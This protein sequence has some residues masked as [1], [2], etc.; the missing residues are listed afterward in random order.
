MNHLYRAPTWSAWLLALPVV[1]LLLLVLVVPV[2]SVLW[3][4]FSPEDGQGPAVTLRHYFDFLGKPLSHQVVVRTLRISVLTTIL[5]ILI[6]YPLAY[7]LA[8]SRSRLR[9]VFL[10]ICVFPLLVS[11]VV[12]AYGWTVVLGKNG[13][14]NTFLLAVG[15]IE[16]PLTLI[17]NETGILIGVTHLLTPYMILSLTTVIQSVDPALEEAAQSLGATPLRV[18]WK[19]IFPLSLPGLVSGTVLVFTLSMTAFATPLMLGG[20]RAPV[21]TTLL[22]QYALVSI[23]WHAAATAGVVLLLLSLGFV[24]F[25]RRLSASGMAWLAP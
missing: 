18:F 19:V 3:R 5:S 6:G 23:N 21:L 1:A 10:A 22:Y 20:A 13:L 17:Y 12:R 16:S 4:S 2:T 9:P 8:K 11:I 15:L 7:F 14:V 25:Y 24:F